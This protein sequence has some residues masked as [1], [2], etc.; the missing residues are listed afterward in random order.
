MGKLKETGMNEQEKQLRSVNGKIRLVTGAKY[1]DFKENPIFRGKYQSELIGQDP[2]NPGSEKVI[3]YNFAD[4]DGEEWVIT[5]AYAV[6]K[7]LE[8][9]IEGTMVKDMDV[10]LEITWFEKIDRPGKPSYN[11]FQI[12]ILG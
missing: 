8:T 11:R 6:S 4:T 9:Q 3:G 12:D 1:W 5:S 7:A 2:S 10:I